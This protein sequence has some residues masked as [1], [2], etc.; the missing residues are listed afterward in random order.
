MTASSVDATRPESDSPALAGARGTGTWSRWDDLLV[1]REIE[2]RMTAVEAQNADYLS[3]YEARR[4][5]A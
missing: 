1:E 3:A 4:D 2:R 5:A